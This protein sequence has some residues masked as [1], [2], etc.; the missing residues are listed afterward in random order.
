M[1]LLP[2]G[3]TSCQV[4]VD[5]FYY[6]GGYV[7][8][9]WFKKDVFHLTPKASADEE[10][11]EFEKFNITVDTRSADDATAMIYADPVIEDTTTGY[12]VG[13]AGADTDSTAVADSAGDAQDDFTSEDIEFSSEY[14]EPETTDTDETVDVATEENDST[15][16]ADQE[17]SDEESTDIE[18]TDETDS[19]IDVDVQTDETVAADVGDGETSGTFTGRFIERV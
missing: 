10:D 5:H 7:N 1:I 18:V 13:N 16:V 11:G 12:N 9:D 2:G 14:Q 15:D 19:S 17:N 6:Q 4:E 8:N 3:D